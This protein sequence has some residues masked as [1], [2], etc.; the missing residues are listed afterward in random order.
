MSVF[1]VTR[2]EDKG[3]DLVTAITQSGHESFLFPLLKL[4]SLPITNEQLT[5]LIDADKI[6]FV[7][8]DAVNYLADQKT[9]FNVNAEFFA[10]GEKTAECIK[11]RFNKKA[12][13]PLQHD[14]EG[15]LGL[16]QL[17]QVDGMSV[18]LIKGKG[19][20]TLLAKTLKE[21]GAVL[22]SI[23]V[24]E[25]VATDGDVEQ[26]ISQWQQQNIDS[27]ILSCTAAVDVI[28][29][30]VTPNH[31]AWLKSCHY[32]V[33]SERIAEYIETY[34]IEANNIM[35]SEGASNEAIFATIKKNMLAD[36]TVN[37][38][39]TEQTSKKKES[40]LIADTKEQESRMNNE[41]KTEVDSKKPDSKNQEAK[42]ESSGGKVIALVSVFAL[43]TSVVAVSGVVYSYFKQQQQ[44]SLVIDL[45]KR[46]QVL[47]SQIE[48]NKTQLKSD[49][50]SITI[51]TEQ[52]LKSQQQRVEG[53]LN[54][55]QRALKSELTQ[56]LKEKQ[57][58]KVSLN[59]QEVKSLQRMAVFKAKAEQDYA[60]A[61]EILVRLDNL[62]S[63]HAGSNQ[64]RKAVNQDIQTLKGLTKAPIESLY[65]TIHGLS[66]QVAGLPFNTNTARVPDKSALK[67][68]TA[69]TENIDDWWPNLK[70]TW[71]LFIDDFVSK[72][73]LKSP[74]KPML[75][76]KQ[77]M[78]IRQEL[79]FYLVQA[80]TALMQKQHNIYGI[81]LH[82]SVDTVNEFFNL[83]ANNVTSML[84]ELAKLQQ[85]QPDFYPHFVL[86]SEQVIKEWSL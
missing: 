2:P 48:Q 42:K 5:P 64:L 55:T 4:K 40:T 56:A 25:R 13:V 52:A 59:P 17:Q 21:K 86:V 81:A 43:L 6:I 15:L 61:I 3:A 27:I 60:G 83:E 84:Q 73:E 70:S 49:L 34:G 72:R 38:A 8:Q 78:L 26:W 23:C 50:E 35:V 71:Q 28:F 85:N 36:R 11:Q 41:N 37:S 77:Q 22:N 58:T 31:L 47:S 68:E 74:I 12:I 14:S 65:L 29:K 18:V 33:V 7:S 69:L 51:A 30:E 63:E 9:K 54:Q 44:Q 19:G 20:R 1:L 32:Y 16:K 46:N 75:T 80:Q 57:A 45:T 10:V 67:K 24:Y 76:E 66:Q 62:L 82:K 53:H 79:S 39:K